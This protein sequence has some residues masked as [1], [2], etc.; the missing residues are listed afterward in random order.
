VP[1]PQL[2]STA[3]VDGDRWVVTDESAM[4]RNTS[5]EGVTSRVNIW[6]AATGQPIG[7]PITV[8]GDAGYVEVDRA[9]GSRVLT[10]TTVPSG[11]DMVLD[12][13]PSD[14]QSVACSIAGRN[15]TQD[16]WK[17]YLPGRPYQRTCPQWP[18]GS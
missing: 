12:L 18:A 3:F 15:L 11:T 14:W 2:Q 1:Y 9:G 16:E 7:A 5:E 4:N 17:Q 10:S 13:D 8:N 6:D